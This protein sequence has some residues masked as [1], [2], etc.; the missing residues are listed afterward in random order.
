[1]DWLS[2]YHV[3]ISFNNKLVFVRTL[4]GKKIMVYG[5]MN[6]IMQSIII[7]IKSMKCVSKGCESLSK[8]ILDLRKERRG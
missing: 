2:I 5:E 6:H 3:N 7:T 8:Y 1:M 4:E